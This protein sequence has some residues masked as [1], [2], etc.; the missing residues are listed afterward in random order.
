MLYV[1]YYL[2]VNADLAYGS[3]VSVA[4]LLAPVIGGL[5]HRHR[6]P[7]W[8][9]SPSTARGSCCASPQARVAGLDQVAYG[10]ML[11][12][13][14]AFVPGGPGQPT[15]AAVMLSVRG[16]SRRFGGL[17][18]VADVS[19]DIV[20]GGITRRHR[21]PTA[22]ARPRCSPPSPGFNRPQQRHGLVPRRRYHA[23][24]RPSARPPRPR[25]HLPDRAALRRPVGARKHRRRRPYCITR[26]AP[27]P[28]PSATAIAGKVGLSAELDKPAASLTVAGRKRLEL[29]RALATEPALLLLDEVCGPG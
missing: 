4:A 10:A 14:I 13:A 16:V 9:R 8:A 18:A 21:P 15:V 17:L 1:Q 5:G 28:W 12:L 25:P 19:L 3:A 27:T 22:R 20:E 7:Y 6:P 23:F 26:D 2:F 29:A 24:A 11:V